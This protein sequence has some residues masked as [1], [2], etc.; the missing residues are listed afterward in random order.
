MA[1][2]N[3]G[4][5]AG[6]GIASNK[7]V[8]KPV[9]TGAPSRGVSPAG[10]NQLGTARGDHAQESGAK[11]LRGDVTPMYGG[12]APINAKA[13]LGNANAISAGQ[14][15]GAGRT[16]HRTGSQ[17]Q[18]GAGAGKAP[19]QGRDI[20]NEYGRDSAAVGPRK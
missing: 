15:A 9:R 6:G 18:W 8:E 13:E 11:K 12:K 19:A 3:S 7:R 4:H 10:V 1:N 16:V 17:Q 5:R 14:G 20:L 2:R